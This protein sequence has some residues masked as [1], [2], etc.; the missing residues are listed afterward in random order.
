MPPVG[1]PDAT[2]PDAVDAGL[3]DGLERLSSVTSPTGPEREPTDTLSEPW[4]QAVSARWFATDRDIFDHPVVGIRYPKRGFAWLWIVGR[5]ARFADS[6]DLKRGQFRATLRG[7]DR[8]WMWGSKSAV[9]RFIKTLIREGMLTREGDLFTVV[10]YDKWQPAGAG[11]EVGQAAGHRSGQRRDRKAQRKQ[12][13]GSHAGTKAGQQPGQ[14][15]GHEVGHIEKRRSERH[16]GKG[17]DQRGGGA[18]GDA[19]TLPGFAPSEPAPP[20]LTTK[21]G[22]NAYYPK[23]GEAERA[24]DRYPDEFEDFWRSY[25]AKNRRRKPAAYFEWRMVVVGGKA[26]PGHLKAAAAKMTKRMGEKP[27]AP[28]RWLKSEDWS[29]IDRPAGFAS[30][31]NPNGRINWRDLTAEEQGTASSNYM[32]VHRTDSSGPPAVEW[33]H[34][35]PPAEQRRYAEELLPT[36]R[37]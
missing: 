30:A 29:G 7:M 20:D 16:E 33:F 4:A 32:T 19:P 23:A 25:P 2:K 11:H 15:P 5:A 6:G 28:V 12:L 3:R 36:G 37:A 14:Q 13:E 22:R 17:D 31:A 35:L 1:Q 9:D 34:S 10:N 24:P 27:F 21:K 26:T 18:S 8:A